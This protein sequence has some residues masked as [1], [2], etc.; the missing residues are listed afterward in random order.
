MVVAEPTLLQERRL[1]RQGYETVI[2]CDEVGR[3]AIAGP[4]S[5]G[6]VSIGRRCGRFPEGLRD[7]K[8][9]APARREALQP[10]VA[11][12]VSA[13]AIGE[14][15]ADEIDETGIIAGLGRAASRGIERL[16]DQGVDLATAVVLLDGSHDWLTPALGPW[17]AELTIVT[18]VKADRDCAAVSA[19]SVLAK[20]GRDGQMVR[21][22]EDFADYAWHSNKGYGS[23]AHW[24]GIERVGPS[25]LHRVTWLSKSRASAEEP[26]PAF[27]S[28]G[29]A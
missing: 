26:L 5:V 17:A 24:A 15:A 28:A 14:S 6:V 19:A 23:A 22:H 18:R 27:T 20:V 21:H 16:A 4:V 9:L 7:S 25:P 13:W 8:M 29:S 3:G 2:G 10:A 11:T 12:W 1:F